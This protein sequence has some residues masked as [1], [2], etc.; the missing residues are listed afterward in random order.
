MKALFIGGT[1]NISTACS[2]EALARGVSVHHL[3]RGQRQAVAGLEGI[4]THHADIRKPGEAAAALD[5]HT[6]DVVVDFIAF[7]AEHIE[8]DLRLFRG[9]CGQYIFISS[10]SAY[11]KPT[12]HL[13]ITES[14]P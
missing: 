12:T 5:N 14:T 13:P 4:H 3:N 7:T 8:T 10:A 2:I 9:R 6:F 11:Q 1:G